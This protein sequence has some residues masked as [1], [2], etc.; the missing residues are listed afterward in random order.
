MPS[1]SRPPD[2]SA[3]PMPGLQMQPFVL[4]QILDGLAGV[5]RLSS[6]VLTWLACDPA[7]L[8]DLLETQAAHPGQ[9]LRALLEGQHC[10]DLKLRIANAAVKAL[11]QSPVFRLRDWSTALGCAYLSQGLANR[12]GFPDE[13]AYLAG[14]FHNLDAF[15]DSQTAFQPRARNNFTRVAHWVEAWGR[16]PELTDAISAQDESAGRLRD[17][18]PLAKLVR[19]ARALVGNDG[20]GYRLASE[21]F[22]E[23]APD[24]IDAVRAQA[25]AAVQGL[26]QK[27]GVP[28]GSASV[29]EDGRSMRAR[30]SLAL[31]S[32]A[33]I[34]SVVDVLGQA[35]D[36]AAVLNVAMDFLARQAGMRQLLYLRHDRM[37]D[38]LLP[39]PE[40]A[41][42]F[43]GL[44]LQVQGS[45]SAA[46]W[47]VSS[48]MPV[49]FSTR[50]PESVSL[51]DVQLARHSG[52]STVVAFP[53]GDFE[54]EGV[55]VG[56]ASQSQSA[57]WEADS[58]FLGKLGRVIGRRLDL[59]RARPCVANAA[60][61]ERQDAPLAKVRRVLHEVSNPL[62]IA[63][64]YLAILGDKLGDQN[65]GADELRIVREELDRIPRMLRSLLADDADAAR[66]EEMVDINAV[67]RDLVVIA[68]SAT[69]TNK[70]VR[71]RSR[72]EPGLPSIR[73]D[74][75]KLKQ[76]LLNLVLNAIDAVP[77]GGQVFLETSR[78]L[79]HQ[80]ARR[81]IVAISDNGPGIPADM[82]KK[83]FEPV[84]TTKGGQHAGLGLSIVKSLALD[85]ALEISC[86]SN[87]SGTTF[88]ISAP[89]P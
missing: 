42:G 59:V 81:L 11:S 32:F 36:E 15:D 62:G 52:Y 49:M 41:G 18:L 78:S 79:S 75:A 13:S 89:L 29:H 23:L 51:F 6:D 5:E 56:C 8:A 31:Q 33:L 35:E 21:L 64:N 3:E 60:T 72:L 46:A 67:I 43:A 34:E 9:N 37:S 65:A 14:L 48:R 71:I 74:Q 70:Q 88:L 44:R 30:L 17:A 27:L 25:E 47:A 55:M 26:R 40:N 7:L 39:V 77:E 61:P 80:G 84:E 73:S 68:E 76:L 38:Q 69:P 10:G 63:K 87:E 83:L 2:S 54:I 16:W 50:D 1:I 66:V 45:H 12:L 53:V 20:D 24:E 19:V 4:A 22:P 82:M 86:L 57:D 58:Q 28:S 85:L